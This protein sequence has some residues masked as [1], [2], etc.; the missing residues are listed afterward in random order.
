MLVVTTIH[1][2]HEVVERKPS[3]YRSRSLMKQLQQAVTAWR[4]VMQ[5]VRS[6]SILREKTI[7]CRKLQWHE[8]GDSREIEQCQDLRS[9][10]CSA[11]SPRESFCIVG[12][13]VQ[14]EHCVRNRSY[15]S[16]HLFLHLFRSLV[17][18]RRECRIAEGCAIPPADN[19]LQGIACRSRCDSTWKQGQESLLCKVTLPWFVAIA[20]CLTEVTTDSDLLLSCQ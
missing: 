6:F 3:I 8:R 4:K 5:S 15:L 14:E 7:S 16:P 1:R 17:L 2:V 13:W 12:R 18:M 19:R 10:K 9:L 11:A 20:V